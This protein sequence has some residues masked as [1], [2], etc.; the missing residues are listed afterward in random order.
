MR[1]IAIVN[2]KGGCGKTTTT[3][4]LAGC[5]AADG[6]RALVAD[7]DPQA[8]ATMALGIDPDAIDENL[9]EVLVDSDAGPGIGAVTVPVS[10]R[11]HLAPSSVVLAAL[12]QR[13][14][15]ER[16]E[17]TNRRLGE[18]LAEV[19]EDY[20]YVLI[21]CPP[22]VGILTLNAM[23]AADEIIIPLETSHFA[24]QG[25]HKVLETITL[26]AERTG[27]DPD[28][29]V[30]S[31]LYDGRTRFGRETL[32]EIRGIFGDL[33]FDTV[34]RFNI[35]LREAAQ[36]GLPIVNFRR[37]SNGAIDYGALAAEVQA[38]QA[39]AEP[40]AREVVIEFRDAD[41]IDVRIA[42]NFNGWIPD[43]GVESITQTEG[44][45]RVWRKILHLHPGVYE[46]RY[47]IDGEWRPD[48]EN[49]EQVQEGLGPPASR[50][51]VR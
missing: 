41:A 43:R 46:Y 34:I 2:Q 27:H 13:L 26:L 23:H 31:T 10:Q 7:L 28:V 15:Q 3:V 48:P 42:G 51:V 29:R 20:D 14:A 9:Y 11:L 30:L 25:V 33:C 6:A 44:D 45:R 16:R 38:A 1:V 21:D 39:Q 37:R 22:N 40:P 17:G 50:L 24:I 5:L 47:V 35:A 8:H 36:R 12:E 4:N 19:Q 49:P 32:G 18:A